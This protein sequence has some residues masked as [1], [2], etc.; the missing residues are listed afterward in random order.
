MKINALRL[1]TAFC[2]LFFTFAFFYRIDN[3]FDQDL[4]R[5]LKLGE[6]IL[7]TRQIPKT[8]LFSYTYP[9]F[10][11]INHHYL[12]EVAIFLGQQTVGLGTI[13]WLKI[14]L[15]MVS[16][17]LTL[18]VVSTPNLLILFP[19][20]F[21]FL[22]LL[23]ERTELRPEIL[24]FFLTALTL[25][26]LVRFEKTRSKLIFLL[27]LI[28]LVWVNTHIYFPVGYLIQAIFFCQFLILQK[29]RAVKTLAIVGLFS[30]ALG[31]L[32]PYTWA[33][34]LYPLRIF[35]NYG[36][37]IVE[38]QNL[39][40]LERLQFHNPNFLFVKLAAVLI[41]SSLIVGAKRRTLTFRNLGLSLL[42]L[43][44]ALVNV[45]SFPYLVFLSLPAVAENCGALKSKRLAGILIPITVVLLITES[46]F[47]LNGSYYRQTDTDT[48]P[49]LGF[50][51]HG[52]KALDFV[53]AQNLPQPIFNNFDIG[54]YIIYRAYPRYRVFV[55]GRPE[56]YPADFFQ[57]VY[58]PIQNN[59]D[60]FK[61]AAA[62][63]NFQTIIFSHTDQTPWGRNF[64]QFIIRDPDWQTVYLDGF[65]IVLVKK[66]KAAGLPE[67]DLAKI[68]PEQYSFKD[69]QS[70]L[71]L[72]LFLLN[73]GYSEPAAKFARDAYRLAPQSRLANLI[74][75]QQLQVPW[76]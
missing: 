63:Y 39:F 74:L 66:E 73:D 18:A 14:I 49:S 41:I 23:R 70:D 48:R 62:F 36:Y 1:L 54:S 35:S 40:L 71:K 5:H 10:A 30:V 55:D 38:N 4:G 22:H 29:K 24:S 59:R 68:T 8:N 3:S 76:W 32:N 25:F 43:I 45:R 34:L 37:T 27:P 60:A 11:F 58:I 26:I 64:L 17:G 61:K 42:G 57:Q 19:A 75:G 20:G 56:S 50:A 31:L 15:I 72:S 67:V 28:Q 2:L 7:Q 47:Y 21:I 9:D 53:L 46:F 52:Q 33:G 44:L 69:Y 13:L 16:V 51:E 12:F 65:I 6:I